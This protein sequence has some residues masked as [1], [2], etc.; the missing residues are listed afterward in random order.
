MASGTLDDIIDCCEDFK[1]GAITLESA[2]FIDSVSGKKYTVG[3]DATIDVDAILAFVCDGD[4]PDDWTGESFL[5]KVA[6]FA[7]GK[8]VGKIVDEAKKKTKVI[9]VVC[10]AANIIKALAC[11]AAQL[12]PGKLTGGSLPG[13]GGSGGGGP[14][15]F[16]KVADYGVAAAGCFDPG[17]LITLADGTIKPIERVMRGDAL[18]ASAVGNVDSVSQVMVLKSDHLRELTFQSRDGSA[19]SRSLRLTHDHRVWVDGRG[20]AFA[21]DVAVGD[22]LHG[23][24][25]ALLEV[26]S[27]IRIPGSHEVIGL[28]MDG[29]NVLYAG[30][31]LVEDQ[32]FKPAPSFQVGAAT[33][34]RP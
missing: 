22:W 24:D 3:V 7:C 25:G 28:H 9:D 20:W 2:G 8:I 21:N 6:D 15:N 16:S 17:T 31:V 23:V 10:K 33:G 14:V 11:A 4:C 5:G 32:C 12:P 34:G 30:G 27:N 19:V 1:Y 26:T 13:G 29:G 18:L